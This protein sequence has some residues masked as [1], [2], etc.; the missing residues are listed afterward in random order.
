[1]TVVGTAGLDRT[2]AEAALA[3]PGVAEL[4]PSLRQTLAGVA[5]LVPRILG[6]SAV[7]PELGVHAEHDSAAA[8]WHVEVR[9]V[10]H[11]DRR[12]LDTARDVREQVRSAV[13]AHL[14]REGAPAPVTV[15]VNVTRVIGA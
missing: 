2:A 13:V 12:A 15:T 4:Q 1:M 3:V 5:T 14:E 6:S 7:S 11:E 9:C 8:S 10:L